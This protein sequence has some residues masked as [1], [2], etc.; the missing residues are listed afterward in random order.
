MSEEVYVSRLRIEHKLGPL[1]FAYLS[2]EPQP[3][4][5]SVH[6]LYALPYIP[7]LAQGHPTHVFSHPGSTAGCGLTLFHAPLRRDGYPS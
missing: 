1:R 3:M 5:F 2:G 7:D 6:G 4:A